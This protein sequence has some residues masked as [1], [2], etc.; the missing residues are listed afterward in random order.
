MMNPQHDGNTCGGH[1]PRRLKGYRR[2][3][4]VFADELAHGQLDPG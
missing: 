4:P 3:S 1:S 2:I